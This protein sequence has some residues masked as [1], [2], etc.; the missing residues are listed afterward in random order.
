MRH[1]NMKQNFSSTKKERYIY[2][3]CIL[4]KVNG[5]FFPTEINLESHLMTERS[6]VIRKD[7]KR[8]SPETEESE[9]I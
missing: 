5:Y 6:E 2:F 4:M 3:F 1:K 7:E 9:N 8:K